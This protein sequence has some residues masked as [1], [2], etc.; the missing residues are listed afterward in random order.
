MQGRCR[1]PLRL[2]FANRRRATLSLRCKLQTEDGARLHMVV[3]EHRLALLEGGLRRR[4]SCSQDRFEPASGRKQMSETAVSRPFL[5][6]RLSRRGRTA[7]AGGILTVCIMVAGATLMLWRSH[8]TT[9]EEWKV[10]LSN[11]STILAASTNQTMKAA[12]LV[13]KSISDR[14]HDADIANVDEFRQEM[15]TRE[16]FDM[17]RNKASSVPQVDVATIVAP[18]GDIINFTRSYPPPRINLADRDYFKAHM[19]DPKL[20]VFLSVPVKNRGT[21]TWTFYLARKIKSR[22]GEVLGLVLTGIESSFFQ[23]FFKAVSI[24]DESAI[25]LFRSDGILLARY[26]TRDELIGKSFRD[27]AVFRDIISRG[28]EGGAVVTTGPRLAD[29]D[30]SQ[31]R[32]VA[33]RSLKDYPLVVNVT[34]TDELILELWYTTAWFIGLGTALFA[35]LLLGLTG[36]IATLLTRQETTMVDLRRARAD[37]EEATQAKT[38]F[39]AMMSHEIRTPMNAVIGMSNMLADTKLDQIQKRFVRI[40]EDSAAHLLQIINDILDFSRLEANRLTIQKADFDLNALAES[41]IDIARGLPGADQIDIAM[42]FAGN[43]P[44]VVS[45]D[46]DRLNQVFLNLLGNA[47]KYTE[48]GAVTLSATVVDQGA[49]SMRIRFSVTD[50]GIGIA[51]EIQ[52][53]LFQPFEQGDLRL[54]RRKGGTGLGLAICKRL[55]DLMGGQIGVLSKAGQGSTFWFELPF[56]KGMAPTAGG[57]GMPVPRPRTQRSLRILVAEDTPANQIVARAMLEKLGHRVQLVADGTEA[58]AAAHN[59]TFDLILM[60]VQMPAMDG[61]E[62]TRRIRKLEGPSATTPIIALTAFAQVSDREKA[63]AAGMTDHISKPIRVDELDAAIE[64]NVQAGETPRPLSIDGELDRSALD[65]LFDAVGPEAFGELIASFVKDANGAL[66]ELRDTASEPA[67]LRA[68]AHRLASLMGQF[69]ATEAADSA[70]AVERAGDAEVRE[71]ADRLLSVGEAAVA[72]V[73]QV[74]RGPT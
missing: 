18:N 46:S 47:V 42:A 19:A 24:G 21:G 36:W 20:D 9:I 68:A 29:K 5:P 40:I 10:N 33:P 63:I 56:G 60:D 57:K 2:Q 44:P 12:D 35:L 6:R 58:V 37:A 23:D 67:R 45:G 28:S 69:G 70:V 8:Q 25:S 30:S 13:L 3:N 15:G 53:R 41:A 74:R 64:R 55:I 16:I 54:A 4:Y 32:I 39:L 31:M 71:R 22:T 14:V 1:R 38:D 11:M 59:G 43:I 66:A 62:A 17:L 26:P 27:Q 61:Y 50:T 49:E 51:P 48:Q 52:E 72:A 7:L 65:E 34:A 73:R